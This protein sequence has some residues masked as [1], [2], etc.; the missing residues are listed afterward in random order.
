MPVSAA[1]LVAVVPAGAKDSQRS[2]LSHK[3]RRL[4]QRW[5]KLPTSAVVQVQVYLEAVVEVAVVDRYRKLVAQDQG[6][7]AQAQDEAQ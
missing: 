2:P 7:V 4:V 6:L 3:P 5:I 1:L